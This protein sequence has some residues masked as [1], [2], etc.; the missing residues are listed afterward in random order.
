MAKRKLKD[1]CSVKGYKRRQKG[2][3]EDEPRKHKQNYCI[4]FIMMVAIFLFLSV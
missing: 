1:F 4:L 3:L 2:F